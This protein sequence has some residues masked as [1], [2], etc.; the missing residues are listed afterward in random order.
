[1]NFKNKLLELT[2]RQIYDALNTYTN[3]YPRTNPKPPF[4]LY[5][6]ILAKYKNGYL[7]EKLILDDDFHKLLYV[8]LDSWG[9]NRRKAKLYSFDEFS[10][11]LKNHSTCIL[12]LNKVNTIT[13]FFDNKNNQ[14]IVSCLWSNLK[15]SNTKSQVVGTSKIMHFLF[16]NVFS[17]IDRKYITNYFRETTCIP[18][19]EYEYF[20]QIHKYYNEFKQK[21]NK[22][23]NIEKCLYKQKYQYN[24]AKIFDDI[25]IGLMKTN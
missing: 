2:N 19:N 22:V 12:E 5:E 6:K 8:T 16:P 3:K 20:I 23:L 1:M 4:Y 9:M 10:S 25:V 11:S 15:I 18:S 17:P 21:N 24:Q 14:T 7:I 13:D